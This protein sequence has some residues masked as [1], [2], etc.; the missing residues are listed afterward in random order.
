MIDDDLASFEAKRQELAAI[1]AEK[2]A[3]LERKK[4]EEEA[5]QMAGAE[6]DDKYTAAIIAADISFNSQKYDGRFK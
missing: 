5:A 2:Q 3:E 1:E 4:A 6:R